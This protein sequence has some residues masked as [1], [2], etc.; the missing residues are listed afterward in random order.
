MLVCILFEASCV[1]NSGNLLETTS[2]G[3]YKSSKK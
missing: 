2:V 3:V 1:V